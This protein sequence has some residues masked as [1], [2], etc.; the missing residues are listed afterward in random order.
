M[1]VQKMYVSGPMFIGGPL[2][3]QT[4]AA[5]SEDNYAHVHTIG[6]GDI[7][8]TGVKTEPGE[9]KQYRATKTDFYRRALL[10]IGQYMGMPLHAPHYVHAS[11]TYEQAKEYI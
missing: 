11:L 1:P 3:A 10:L 7:H 9:P 5:R 4:A 6:V 2:H 8:R